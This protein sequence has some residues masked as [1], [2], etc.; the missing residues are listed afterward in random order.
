MKVIYKMTHNGNWHA[1]TC[2][3]TLFSAVSLNQV[4]LYQHPQYLLKI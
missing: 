4:H 2:E 1:W 3:S